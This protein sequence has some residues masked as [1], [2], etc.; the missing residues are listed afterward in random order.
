MIDMAK[1]CKTCKGK[2]VIRDKKK[3][4]VD[5]D[6]GSPNGEQF[7]IHGEGDCVPGVEPG[8]V[9]VVIKIRPNKMF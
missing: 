2:K 9:V 8:D 3:L 6:K 7:T 5:I 1:R 4:S